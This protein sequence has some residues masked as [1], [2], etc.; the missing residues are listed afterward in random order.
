[1][2]R[3]VTRAM[4]CDSTI[5][6]VPSVDPSSAT[7]SVNGEVVWARTRAS[8]SASTS[9]RLQVMMPIPTRIAMGPFTRRVAGFYSKIGHFGTRASDGLRRGENPSPVLRLNPSVRAAR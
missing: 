8:V 6:V 9:L 1:M 7:A 5:S 3:P 2:F 4:F